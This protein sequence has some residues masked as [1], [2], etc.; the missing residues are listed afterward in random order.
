MFVRDAGQWRILGF[1]LAVTRDGPA[2]DSAATS[3]TT[4]APTGGGP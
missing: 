1:D 4:A 2:V 3:T